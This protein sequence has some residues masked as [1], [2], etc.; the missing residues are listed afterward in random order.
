[1]RSRSA[2]ARTPCLGYPSLTEAVGALHRQGLSYAAIAAR[3]GRP[4]SAIG[5][6]LAGWR[7]TRGLSAP[8]RQRRWSEGEDAELLALRGKGSSAL[9][10]AIALDRSESGVENRL[11][12]L[13]NRA[14][15]AKREAAAKP[16]KPAKR[17]CLR[18]QARFRLEQDYRL[19]RTCRDYATDN[20][21]L[22][23]VDAW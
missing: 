6:L 1:M 22:A 2:G 5:P 13:R 11:W 8:G 7:K 15:A 10:C 23:G 19:C 12:W 4:T 21:H 17:R 9:D 20:S 3:V 14:P 18:C 16:A